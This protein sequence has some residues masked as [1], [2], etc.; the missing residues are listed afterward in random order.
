MEMDPVQ[1]NL[2]GVSGYIVLWLFTVISLTFFI[3]R[4]YMIVSILRKANPENRFDNFGSRLMNFIKYVL[5]QKKLFNESAIGFP[6]FMFF[7]GFVFYA[8]SFWWNLFKGLIPPLPIPYADDVAIISLI[9]E[10]SGILV[11]LSIIVAVLRR[12]FFAPEHLQKSRDAAIIL[13]LITILMIT[14]ILGQG[15]KGSLEPLNFSLAGYFLSPSFSGLEKHTLQTLY[16]WMWWIHISTVLVFL[17]YIPYSKHLHLLASPFNVF[18]RNDNTPGTLDIKGAKDDISVGAAVWNE[19]TWKDLLNSFSCAECGRCDRVCPALN[20]GFEL[21]PRE[22]LHN[23]K[24]QMYNTVFKGSS[25]ENND[26]FKLIGNLITDEV[27]WQCTTCMSCMEQC[28][29]LNE[30]IPVIISLRRQLVSEG[31]I[32]QTVQDMLQKMSRYGN[33]FGQS[34]RNRP[35]WTQTLDFK[36]KD[37]RKEEVEYLW[38]VGDYASF[39][40]R[41]NSSTISVANIFQSAGLDYGILYDGERNSGN[42]VRRI[43][44]EGLF[45]ILKEK[46]LLNMSKSTFKTIVTTDPHTYNT[47]KKE[48]D[49]TSQNGNGKVIVKHYT[50]IINDLIKSKKLKIN[51]Q[52]K[53]KA[54]YHD[55]CYL[56][57]YNGIYEQPRNILKT[58]GIDL[59]EMPRNRSKSYC[60]GAGGGRIWMEDKVQV[61][62]RPSE[63]R[64]NE[65]VSLNGVNTLIVACPKD[66]VMFQDAIKTTG[67]EEKISVKDLGELVWEAVK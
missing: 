20:S 64:I 34:D 63:S 10:V 14:L 53:I 48:Y 60:C 36:I 19:F 65:A 4:V 44:E 43:G 49:L 2:F 62:E 37:A 45:E 21:S 57:R 6:H 11:L 38:Y 39:D 30:H 50:E 9:L 26:K 5:G 22:I 40:V 16:N 32:G 41:V 66:I 51:N 17:A 1:I 25:A 42:D 8:T 18:F 35:K 27:I 47:L 67:N 59:V 31:S 54:T 33:S 61:K 15:F 58:L 24:D 56:G 23:I 29:V 12:L 55:P 52:I 13:T 3:R 28:P 7:W 46:N